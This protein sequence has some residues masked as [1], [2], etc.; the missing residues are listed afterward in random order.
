MMPSSNAVQADPGERSPYRP[1][2]V[3]SSTI[4]SRA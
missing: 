2:R 1:I 3:T 4:S